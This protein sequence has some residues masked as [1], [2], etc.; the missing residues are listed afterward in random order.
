MQLEKLDLVTVSWFC[1]LS[2][3]NYLQVLPSFSKPRA[4]ARAVV[5]RTIVLSESS[6]NKIK[7][8]ETRPIGSYVSIEFTMIVAKWHVRR[9]SGAPKA[10]VVALSF[11]RFWAGMPK[12]SFRNITPRCKFCY[13]NHCIYYHSTYKLS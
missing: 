1:Y 11:C 13:R 9:T 12:T 7:D 5:P 2:L 6:V 3:K 4:N 8:S 10:L